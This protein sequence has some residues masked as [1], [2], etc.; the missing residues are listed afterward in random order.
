[1]E[2]CF[3]CKFSVIRD[4]LKFIVLTGIF[5]PF[6]LGNKCVAIQVEID[7]PLVFLPVF[8]CQL[9]LIIFFPDEP[10]LNI[11][12]NLPAMHFRQ[13]RERK[14]VFHFHH[15]EPCFSEVKGMN[16]SSASQKLTN[17]LWLTCLFKD[18]LPAQ[19]LR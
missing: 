9:S 5:P 18:H 2:L 1:M 14:Q 13:K 8:V 11:D 7:G 16:L 3:K 12:L 19:V 10:C 6:L 15:L 4:R 17:K